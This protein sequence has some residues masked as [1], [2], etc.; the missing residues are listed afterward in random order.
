MVIFLIV[1]VFLFSFR[2]VYIL[3]NLVYIKYVN[4]LIV[5]YRCIDIFGLNR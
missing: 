5:G 2:N 1:G 3:D 4:G